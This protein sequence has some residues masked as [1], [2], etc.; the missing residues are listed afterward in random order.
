MPLSDREI[1]MEL[2]AGSLQIDPMP[3]V[4]QVKS[5]SIDLTLYNK[6]RVYKPI[7]GVAVRLSQVNANQLADSVT[8]WI[9]LDNNY[10]L[11]P[12][13]NV[14]IGY[15]AEKV[16]LPSFLSGRVEGRSSFARLGLSVHNTA[17]TIQPG[18]RGQI[19]L[20][21]SNNGPFPLILEPGLIICQLILERLVHPT[22]GYEGQF[23]EQ[24]PRV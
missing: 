8:D 15:T 18:F 10:E 17:P 16:S 14:I 5:A 23:Q 12:R 4:E 9:D 24:T 2:Q 7:G 13:D 19:A 1:W 22:A 6:A 3:K 20:E 11:K 21:L